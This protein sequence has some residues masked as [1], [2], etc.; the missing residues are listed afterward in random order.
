[1]DKTRIGDSEGSMDDIKESDNIVKKSEDTD[2]DLLV[3]KLDTSKKFNQAV[4]ENPATL[5]NQRFVIFQ[6]NINS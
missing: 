1:M 3:G 2:R 5:S 4:S 6:L